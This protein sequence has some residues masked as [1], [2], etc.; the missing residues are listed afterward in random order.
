MNKVV[1]ARDNVA[2]PGIA[3]AFPQ[4]AWGS[5]GSDF[6]RDAQ[7]VATCIETKPKSSAA[8]APRQTMGD[9]FHAGFTQA[10]CSDR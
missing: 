4:C 2:A 6:R 10:R 8:P 1:S 5:A 7:A 3:H 9:I